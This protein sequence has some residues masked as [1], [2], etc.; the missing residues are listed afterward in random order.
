MLA[1]L[2]IAKKAAAAAA[3]A[4]V[5]ARKEKAKRK[6]QDQKDTAEPDDGLPGAKRTDAKLADNHGWKEQRGIG[7]LKGERDTRGA[8]GQDEP[9]SRR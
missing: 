4:E 5:K 1:N 2:V 6:N 8:G 9:G 7:E 3:A